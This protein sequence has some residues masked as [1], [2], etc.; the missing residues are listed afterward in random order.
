MG[1]VRHFERTATGFTSEAVAVHPDVHLDLVWTGTSIKTAPRIGVWS[2]F[3]RAQ[4][5][6]AALFCQRSTDAVTTA[7][8]GLKFADIQTIRS[9]IG[10]A[11][12]ALRLLEK[13]MG[14]ELE[15]GSD[16]ARIGRRL[17]GRRPAA[18]SRARAGAT[19]RSFSPSA[20]GNLQQP[21]M[22]SLLARPGRSSP[23]DWAIEGVRVEVAS[24]G[25][26]RPRVAT[27]VDVKSPKCPIC[28]RTVALKVANECWFPFCS[29]RCKVVDLSR[30]AERRLPRARPGGGQ[31]ATLRSP[32]ERR[33]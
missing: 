25:R 22:R 20:T 10:A 8:F 4:P 33:S 26:N 27:W 2:D 18:S 14:I 19:V 23:V 32:G 30:V 13:E 16:P 15:T 17:G 9:G 28:Q 3:V 6:R 7:A 29:N 1:G 5:E 12:S 24:P 21:S 11:R 31:K